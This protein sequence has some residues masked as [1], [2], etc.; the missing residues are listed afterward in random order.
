ML[1]AGISSLQLKFPLLAGVPLP[2]SRCP[3][4]APP[5]SWQRLSRSCG[6]AARRAELQGEGQD[7]AQ[8]AAPG[9]THGVNA[10]RTVLLRCHWGN[11]VLEQEMVMSAQLLPSSCFAFCVASVSCVP[12]YSWDCARPTSEAW[13]QHCPV[14]L[15]VFLLLLKM[16]CFECLLFKMLSFILLSLK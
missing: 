15:F 7:A 14:L 11:V 10:P 16:P 1:W 8:E 6:T 4:P 5:P 2:A 12:P 13:F 3:V 9:T